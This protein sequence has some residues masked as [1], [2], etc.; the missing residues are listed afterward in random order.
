MN[1]FSIFTLVR[2]NELCTKE[3]FKH[4]WD[5]RTS[6]DLESES[7][8][9]EFVSLGGL[10]GWLGLFKTQDL[11]VH[12]PII[13]ELINEVLEMDPEQIVKNKPVYRYDPEIYDEDR[14][15]MEMD[16]VGEF[17]KFSDYQ[18]LLWR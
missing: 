2:A 3:K 13:S 9:Q 5:V 15:R 12:G 18:E 8:V 6:S 17:V 16:E 10:L 1:Q 14:V 7:Y 11:E 4:F